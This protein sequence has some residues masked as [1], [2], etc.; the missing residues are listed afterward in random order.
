M[1]RALWSGA[2]LA[3]GILVVAGCTP[4][5]PAP[6]GP[7]A[8]R[9]RATWPDASLAELS[10][11][12]DLLRSHCAACHQVP[13]PR[14]HAAVAWPGLV[15]KMAERAHLND[16]ERELIVRYLVTMASAP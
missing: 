2:A 12:R 1:R 3:L 14:S 11:G 4:V 6:T 5:L 13:A 16:E 7:D 9:A 8:V 10:R 15:D